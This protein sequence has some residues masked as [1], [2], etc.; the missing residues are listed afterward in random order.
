MRP[1]PSPASQQVSADS[2]RLLLSSIQ[3][4]RIRATAAEAVRLAQAALVDLEGLDESLYLRFKDSEGE[5]GEDTGAVITS[6]T[7]PLTNSCRSGTASPLTLAAT[8]WSPTSEW[9]A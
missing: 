1:P 3:D 5:L 4:P 2:V 6:T 7:S 8:V 9:I